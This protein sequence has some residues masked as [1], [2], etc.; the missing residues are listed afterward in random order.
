[1]YRVPITKD[2]GTGNWPSYGKEYKRTP[3]F[4]GV[5]FFICI[6]TIFVKLVGMV[7]YNGRRKKEMITV[8]KGACLM[9]EEGLKQDWG[10]RVEGNTIVAVGPN[11]EIDE[12]GADKVIDAKGKMIAPG[13]VNGHNHMYGVLSH[14][15]TTEALVTEFS[16]FLD[17]F[18]W[19]YVEDRIDHEL[20]EKTARWACVEA[21]DSGVTTF[22]DI[23]EGPNSIP[24]ALNIEKKVLEDAG[25]RGILCFEA[26]QRQSEENAQLGLKE[27]YDFCK[28]N[29]KKG[30]L[31]EGIMSIHTLF[32]GDEGFVMGAKAMADELGTDIHMHMSESVFEP[33]WCLDKYGKRT[34][35]VYEDFG[36]LSENVLAS[37]GVQLAQDEIDIVA[38]RGTRIVHM[39][40][41]NCEV[42]GGFAPIP[43]YLEAG[44]PVGIG[45]DGYVNNFFEVMRGAFLVHKAHKQ[46]P[47]VMPADV[48]YKMATSLGADA[49]KRDDLGRLAVG[50]KADIITI[51]IDSPTPINEHN[52]YD[53]VIL[54]RNPN[55]VSEVMIDGKLVKEDYEIKTIDVQKAKAEMREVTERFWQFK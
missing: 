8:F 39:P 31:V 25:V 19:P 37:Q 41:S 2:A 27:N 49:I 15:I 52:V 34:V 53:Q 20:V 5:R 28:E 14:G 47:Q 40:L 12:A 23:L 50:K 24:G 13:F 17:D 32:T 1:M 9:T 18:W 48:V 33:N 45:S 30:G 11:A 4:A 21:I 7:K 6:K 36:F 26:C 42:G 44:V 35:N 51:N 46:D 43:E 22:V 10:V 38:K 54:F 29:N 3:A 55:N 16:S